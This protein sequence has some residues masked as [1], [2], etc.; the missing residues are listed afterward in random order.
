MPP[1]PA[2][3]A[4]QAVKRL[5]IKTSDICNPM[6]PTKLT[7]EWAMRIAEEH[8]DEARSTAHLYNRRVFY[9]KRY[10]QY[11]TTKNSKK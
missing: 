10:L 9:F 7:V 2:Q 3:E 8:F 5:I 4:I 1:R 11:H 6:R